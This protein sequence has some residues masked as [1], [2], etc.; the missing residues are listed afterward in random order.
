VPGFFRIKHDGSN[1]V[2]VESHLLQLAENLWNL[3]DPMVPGFPDALKRW[4]DYMDEGEFNEVLIASHLK[5]WGISFSFHL[6]DDGFNYDLDVSSTEGDVIAVESKS[7]VTGSERDWQKLR[8]KLSNARKQLPKR[9]GSVFVQVPQD[10]M[11]GDTA[12]ISRAL[13]G[14]FTSNSRIVS[15]ILFWMT[16]VKLED[17]NWKAVHSFEVMSAFHAFP[18]TKTWAIFGQNNRPTVS[19]WTSLQAIRD[20]L[21]NG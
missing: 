20:F 19:T 21:L 9:P 1:A 2:I 11:S 18:K 3:F 6:G 13:K 17:G 14:F 5:R 10:W 8:N 16:G 15:V 12:G 4:H 7:R